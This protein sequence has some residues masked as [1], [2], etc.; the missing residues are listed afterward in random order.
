[1]VRA[2]SNV[3]NLSLNI[4]H[5]ANKIV[6]L[7]YLI[8]QTDPDIVFVHESHLRR[9]DKT[10]LIP[11]FVSFASHACD[12]IGANGLLTFFR[13]SIQHLISIVAQD[14]FFIHV[15]LERDSDS[16]INLINFYRPV[17]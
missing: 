6:E 7:D 8:E 2:V 11:N 5:V 4:N 15:R 17:K 13:K 3:T 1:M 16:F 12:T 14:D 9:Q 10:V